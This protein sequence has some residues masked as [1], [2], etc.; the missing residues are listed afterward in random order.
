MRAA[1]PRREFSRRSLLASLT[2][3]PAFAFAGK[4]EEQA[5]DAQRFLDAATEFEILR[6]T[7]LEHNAWLPYPEHRVFTRRAE[8][9]VFASDRDGSLQLYRHEFKPN[10]VRQLTAV[11][12]LHKDNFTLAAA[13]RFL[14]YI[15][16]RRIIQ[17]GYSNLRERIL[18]D[19]PGGWEHSP[20]LAVSDDGATVLLACSDGRKTRIVVPGR[21]VTTLA[22][23]DTPCD[24]LLYRPRRGGVAVLTAGKL[25]AVAPGA[26]GAK[27][28]K[29]APGQVLHAV[30]SP[31]GDTLL[32]LLKPDQPGRLHELRELQPESGADSLLAKT[33]QFGAIASNGDASVI[34]GASSSLAAPH[35]LLLVR[36][37]K[38]ELTLCE[39]RAASALAARP[40]FAPNSNRIAYQTSRHGNSVLYAMN[41]ERLVEPTDQD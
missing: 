3:L 35:L 16:G 12:A 25:F 21:T 1:P 40:Q 23:F 19:L 14:L 24:A 2:G 18:G 30:F 38:R 8:A 22:E 29:T 36:S 6:V 41:V 15:D 4:G 31:Q 34:L 37:V 7:K 10:R 5:G 28:L 32:Y 26:G 17:A 11:A 27:P 13:D 20:R 33:S 9:V 39:H